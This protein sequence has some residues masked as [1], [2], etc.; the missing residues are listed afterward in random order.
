MGEDLKAIPGLY[1]AGDDVG[2]SYGDDYNHL[3]SGRCSAFAMFSGC[4]ATKHAA[5]YLK[6]SIAR[7]WHPVA[8][9]GTYGEEARAIPIAFAF[10]QAS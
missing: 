8:P 2:G 5:E 7:Y 6:G 10:K 4:Y 3:D 1:V 9:R